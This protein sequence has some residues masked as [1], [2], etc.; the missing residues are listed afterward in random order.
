MN[1]LLSR[2]RVP[3]AMYRVFRV[4]A[5]ESAKVDAVLKDD[6]AGRQSILV[7]DARSLGVPGEGMVVLVEGSEAGVA[8]AEALLQ[9]L[10]KVLEGR[11]AEEALARFRSQD[12][13]AV[14]GMGLVFGA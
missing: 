1:I 7:R 5:G 10:G 6:V 3:A 14:S 4:P 12:D 2:A 13:D 9:G 11:E 8:R